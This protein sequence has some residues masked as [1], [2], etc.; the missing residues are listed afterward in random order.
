MSDER[1]LIRE[2]E[3][4]GMTRDMS[5]TTNGVRE[6]RNIFKKIS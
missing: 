4:R 5:D 6:E 3:L 1:Q 2:R